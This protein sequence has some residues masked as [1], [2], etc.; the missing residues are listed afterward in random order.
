MDKK[1]KKEKRSAYTAVSSRPA[2]QSP[3]LVVMTTGRAWCY[4]RVVLETRF[5]HFDVLYCG[6]SGSL[7]D[8][9]FQMLSWPA[10]NV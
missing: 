5:I 1:M 8:A 4:W 10:R 6:P 2:P 3:S 7:R 9:A